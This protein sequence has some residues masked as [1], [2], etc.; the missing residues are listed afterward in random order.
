MLADINRQGMTP[1]QKMLEETIEKKKEQYNIEN[2][3]GRS[4]RTPK[5]RNN[6]F[7]KQSSLPK[8]LHAISED[9]L[10]ESM[11]TD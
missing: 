10:N 6:Y 9:P 3:R 5:G 11:V 8:Y 4:M 7:R 1:Q 2:V